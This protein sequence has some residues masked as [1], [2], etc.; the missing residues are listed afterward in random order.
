MVSGEMENRESKIS[1]KLFREI[2]AEF[3]YIRRWTFEY[4]YDNLGISC[5]IWLHDD[6]RK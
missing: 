3:K 6:F 1:W 2:F 5:A 4:K